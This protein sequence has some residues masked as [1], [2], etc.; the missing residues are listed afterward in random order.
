M[1]W[2]MSPVVIW[3]KIAN[4]DEALQNTRYEPKLDSQPELLINVLS[5]WFGMQLQ[6]YCEKLISWIEDHMLEHLMVE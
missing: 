5:E 1:G 6:E 3:V 2:N 4:I